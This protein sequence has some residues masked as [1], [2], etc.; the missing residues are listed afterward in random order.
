MAGCFLLAGLLG[1]AQGVCA[2]DVAPDV[3]AKKVTDE[4]LTILRADKEIQAG[5]TRKLYDLVEA[6][7]LPNFNFTR[8]TRLAVGAPW[9]QASAIPSPVSEC[10]F[11]VTRHARP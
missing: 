1:L 10:A 2:Q 11:E 4:V 6:K 5:N 3:L 9:R 7:V 8:M